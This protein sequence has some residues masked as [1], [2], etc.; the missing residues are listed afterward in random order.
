M[1]E[2]EESLLVGEV[3]K[4][5]EEIGEIKTL[6]FGEGEALGLVAEHKIMWRVHVWLLCLFSGICGTALTLAVQHYI[7]FKP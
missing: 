7:R 3:R 4:L 5:R 2:K 6:I 1:S